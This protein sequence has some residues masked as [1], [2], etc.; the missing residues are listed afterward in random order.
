MKN[1]FKGISFTQVLAGSL[2]A[3]TSFL[4]ASKIG[5]A[6]SVIGVAI[7]SIVSA[8][9]SQLYQN[10]IHAS[11]RKLAEANP[12]NLN[13][14]D[15]AGYAND[16]KQY[17]DNVQTLNMHPVYNVEVRNAGYKVAGDDARMAYSRQNSEV[18]SGRTISSEAKDPEL[19]NTRL[20]E[21]S[22]LREQREEDMELSEGELS[23]PVPLSK[24]IRDS[25]YANESNLNRPKNS[26]AATIAIAVI[27]ALVAVVV[28]AGIVLLFTQG[29]GTD[30]IQ[31]Q[32]IQQ[33][34]KNQ[35]NP[36]QNSNN[37][38]EHKKPSDSDSE[39]Q[40]SEKEDENSG[41]HSRDDSDS[42]L[43]N[44]AD[45]ESGGDNSST[46]G[47]SHSG[48]STSGSNGSGESSSSTAPGG[49]SGSS[50]NG[51]SGSSSGGA[52]GGASTSGNAE[53]SGSSSGN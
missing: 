11:S 3:V 41:L 18:N 34:P 17:K 5:I 48:E 9:A 42:N 14:S 21:L 50:S 37:G 16:S 23:Q 29:K 26:Y 46:S 33:K 15:S 4:L 10:V 2:A 31:P 44:S 39:N 49:A 40:D 30:N 36:Q 12:K 19:E 53:N 13:N 25:N 8:V 7:G 24:A 22:A 27:S 38:V 32:Q 47:G 6:G 45:G 20:L 35:V 1:F 51:G 43:G 52:S 28:T